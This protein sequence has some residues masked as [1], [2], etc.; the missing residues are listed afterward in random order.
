MVH[1]TLGIIGFGNMTRAILT[2]VVENGL[3]LP[4]N[5][6]IYNP[7]P[8]KAADFIAKGCFEATSAREAAQADYVLLGVKPF[9][10]MEILD[11]I[12]DLLSGRCLIAIAAGIT[13]TS[14]QKACAP[15]TYIVRTM[16][17]A[18]LTV[19]CG[20]TVLADTDTAPFEMFETVKS[21]F[22]CGGIVEVLPENK[23]NE[24]TA[25][26]GSSPAF[27]YRIIAAM[28]KNAEQNGI[29]SETAYRLAVKTMEGAAKVM[30]NTDLSTD[31]LIR[32]VATPG[33]TTQAALENMDASGFDQSLSDAMDACTKRTYELAAK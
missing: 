28:V 8:G 20:A 24:I 26:S 17:N 22:A 23:I 31:Q 10:V 29:S 18:T 7:T 14:M 25:V 19:G 1:K 16:P 15:G 9:K 12:G 13:T 11:E 21:I 33:G 32:I 4:Q 5:I 27:F 3:F 2:P 6:I 30:E